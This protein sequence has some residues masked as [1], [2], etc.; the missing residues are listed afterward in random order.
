MPT[1]SEIRAAL[2]WNTDLDPLDRALL[3]EIYETQFLDRTTT[4]A[5]LARECGISVVRV[6]RRLRK[7]RK[8]QLVSSKQ[9]GQSRWHYDLSGLASGLGLRH[10]A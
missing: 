5:Q 9:V 10:V 6:A 2:R 7:L 4:H 3:T 8:R 1:D